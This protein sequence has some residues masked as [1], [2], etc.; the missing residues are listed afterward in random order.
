MI[1]IGNKGQVREPRFFRVL[2]LSS[3]KNEHAQFQCSS[4]LNHYSNGCFVIILEVV[5]ED[6]KGANKPKQQQLN[7]ETL[8][9]ALA[10]NDTDSTLTS[11]LDDNT[12]KEGTRLI[13]QRSAFIFL[14]LLLYCLF[15]AETFG[16]SLLYDDIGGEVDGACK[17][18]KDLLEDIN[19]EELLEFDALI[20]AKDN[21][22]KGGEIE[23]E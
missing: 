5:T 2:L 20:N 13:L 4:Y 18:A 22:S 14:N 16:V 3:L 6:G 23:S 12:S 9:N 1:T 17:S 11:L 10:S 8:P 21:E 15:D 19:I 7:N